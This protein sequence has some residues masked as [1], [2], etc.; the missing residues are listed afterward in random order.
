V[1]RHGAIAAV[2]QSV[3]ALLRD[4]C[5]RGE[6]PDAAFALLSSADFDK[7]PP[8]GLT[9]FLYR[10][11]P[12]AAR[13]NLGG[14][15]D[16]AV[17]RRP[18]MV[19]D[20]HY[21]LSAWASTAEKQHRLLGWSMRTIEDTAILPP[22]LLNENAAPDHDTF[23]PDES[24]SL[25]PDP[26]SLQDFFN[27]WELAGKP[28]LPASTSYVARLLAIDSAVGDAEAEPVRLRRLDLHRPVEP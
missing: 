3:L 2:G 26:L 28:R 4:A 14:R 17:R 1:A 10:V 12:S 21:L 7:P 23:R 18:P 25:V 9:L 20:V 8:Q 22:T 13:R 19:V 15:T 11:S 24:V 27:V 5:P 6:F 16:G